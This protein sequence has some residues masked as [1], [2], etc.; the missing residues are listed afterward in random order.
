VIENSNIA[1]MDCMEDVPVVQ[2]IT[3]CSHANTCWAR[4]LAQYKKAVSHKLTCIKLHGGVEN[5]Y[6]YSNSVNY[7][8]LVVN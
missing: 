6:Y 4:W 7:G 3:E 2:A 5:S 1:F 8:G